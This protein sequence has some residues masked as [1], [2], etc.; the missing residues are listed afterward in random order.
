MR[1]VPPASGAVNRTVGGL[2]EIVA[3]RETLSVSIGAR[4]HMADAERLV[5]ALAAFPPSARLTLD[6]ATVRESD[7]SALMLVARALRDLSC[8]ELS[9]RGLTM[10]QQRLLRYLGFSD[11]FATAFAGGR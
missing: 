9:L 3:T 8:T 2:V 4:F 7:D 10:H 11:E 1:S 5:E 6:F